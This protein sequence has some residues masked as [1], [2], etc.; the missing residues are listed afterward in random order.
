MFRRIAIFVIL[1]SV[2]L[3]LS[4]C[5]NSE[6]AEFNKLEEIKV[7]EA[8]YLFFQ[9]NESKQLK[10]VLPYKLDQLHIE[11]LA[12][13]GYEEVEVRIIGIIENT[14]TISIA[15]FIPE[16]DEVK[17]IL[18]DGSTLVLSV[19]RHIL[20]MIDVPS[21]T[22]QTEDNWNI[23]NLHSYTDE[24][25]SYISE[26]SFKNVNNQYRVGL[27]MPMAFIHFIEI[28]QPT[29]TKVTE[30]KY[31]YRFQITD[32]FLKQNNI[33]NITTETILYQENLI[34][35]ERK[36]ILKE[37]IPLSLKVNPQLN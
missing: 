17:V 26:V 14:I 13:V 19:G 30:S 28:S 1:I 20:E 5:N 34:T 21:T 15:K 10:L 23:D 37:L 33:Q 35:K 16:F 4:A 29:I 25:L 7:M 27:Y 9:K 3:G 8:N 12:I 32:H 18:N 36:F 2:S 22:T 6:R 31:S 24:T 11:K